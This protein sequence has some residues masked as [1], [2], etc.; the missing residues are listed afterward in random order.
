M[1]VSGTLEQIGENWSVY[2]G[3]ATPVRATVREVVFLRR[4]KK[5]IP[6]SPLREHVILANGDQ[7]PGTVLELTGDQ[8]RIHGHLGNGEDFTIPFSSVSVIWITTPDGIDH[9]AQW[10]RRLAVNKRSRD[11]VYLRNGDQVEGIV[12][13]ITGATLQIES[14]KKDVTVPYSKVGAIA[15]NSQLVRPLQPNG[16]HGRLVLD[17]GLRLTLASATCDSH[18]LKAKTLFGGELTVPVDRILALDWLG[19]CAVYLSDLKPRSYQFRSF[20]EGVDWP[21][22]F[23]ASVAETDLRLDGRVF[24]KGLGLHTSSRLSYDLD[25]NVIRF[26]ALVGLDE[27]VGSEGN[28]R[29]LVLLDG[30][31]QKL[32]WDGV[33]T[34]GGDP[35][36]VRVPV[37]GNREITLVA[38]VGDFGDVQGCV[39]WADARLIR[40]QK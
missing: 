11:T 36:S 1:T 27:V 15:F 26:E 35:H 4:D 14:A 30:K 40:N 8:L 19:G 33:V 22:V 21:Y 29:I 24:H 25:P 17:N 18:I 3:G 38:E 5:A 13:S 28:A 12:N 7:L 37:S 10:R 31:P 34:G 2:F 32:S 6:I 20:L 23:D 39:D 16:N 9:P